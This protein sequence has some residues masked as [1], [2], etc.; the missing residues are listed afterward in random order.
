MRYKKASVIHYVTGAFLFYDS[1]YPNPYIKTA[2][3]TPATLCRSSLLGLFFLAPYAT[4]QADF[5]PLPTRDQNP[6]NLIHGQ[7]LPIDAA[8]ADKD[9]LHINTSLSITNTLNI[10]KVG[11]DSI[12][13]DVESYQLNLGLQYGLG[14]NWAVQMN[15][16]L[17][18]QGGGFLDSAINSWHDLFNL[19]QADRPNVADNQ[20]RIQRVKN[21]ISKP[22]CNQKV[23]V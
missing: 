23:P 10:E 21:N 13:L 17:I 11:S 2:M 5:S 4:A 12:F 9:Q 14:K 7:P 8:V 20:Y 19:P 15:I 1:G 16:P 6:F 18:H 3:M 22:I